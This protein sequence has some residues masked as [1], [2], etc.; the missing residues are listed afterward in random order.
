MKTLQVKIEED[1]DEALERTAKAE[2]TSKSELVRRYVRERI[3]PLPPLEEDPLT[4][5]AGADDYEPAP[6]DEVVY[7]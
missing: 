6:I 7:R 3:A 2:Q 5:M 1:L 4:Q